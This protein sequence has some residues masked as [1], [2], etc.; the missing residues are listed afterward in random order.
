MAIASYVQADG[1][2]CPENIYHMNHALKIVNQRIANSHR[3]SITNDTIFA[4]VTLAAFEVCAVA[5][6]YG[7]SSKTEIHINSSD[8][9]L[10][11]V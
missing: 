5:P 1:L 7:F 2:S 10:Q 9:A 11:R 4:V 6:P 8:P 3:I